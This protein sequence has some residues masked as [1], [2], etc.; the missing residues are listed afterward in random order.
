MEIFINE[1]SLH[2]QYK[3]LR[4]FTEALKKFIGIFSYINEQKRKLEV[5]KLDTNVFLSKNAILN[6]AFQKSLEAINPQLKNAFTQ[7]IFARLNPKDWKPN[8]IHSSED[9][10]HYKDLIAAQ[11]TSIAEITER[12]LQDENTPRVLINFTNSNFENELYLAVFKNDIDQLKLPINVAMVDSKEMFEKWIS[13]YTEK[14]IVEQYNSINE[15]WEKREEVFP[16]L[17]F[18]GDTQKQLEGF[19][20]KDKELRTIFEKLNILDNY[21]STTEQLDFDNLNFEISPESTSTMQQYGNLR[22]FKLPNGDTE[23]FT[24]HIKLSNLRIH[25]FPTNKG[26]CYIGYI[27]KHLPTKKFN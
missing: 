1:E 21:L 22:K 20:I 15:I 25:I 18:C 12:L 7:I 2:G 8:Q 26:K 23:T 17:I 11:N 19:G 14:N 13:D 10:Y 6:D 27:G 16:N 24:L 5:Y 3:D 9:T 4:E